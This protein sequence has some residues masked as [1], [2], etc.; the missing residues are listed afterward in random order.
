MSGL[1]QRLAKASCVLRTA[2]SNLAV[3]AIFLNNSKYLKKK[4]QPIKKLEEYCDKKYKADYLALQIKF[5]DELKYLSL[6]LKTYALGDRMP[7][8]IKKLIEIN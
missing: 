6:K 5:L 4:T 3:S 8:L 2:S 1:N 7:N